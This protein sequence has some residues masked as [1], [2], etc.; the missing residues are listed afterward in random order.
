MD[1]LVSFDMNSLFTKVPIPE[2]LE[3]IQRR[4]K[5]DTTLDERTLMS[6]GTVCHLVNLYMTSTYFEFEGLLF[7]QIEGAPMD[8]PLSPVI[9]DIYYMEFF[10][11][12]AIQEAELEP[13][14]WL[15]YIDNTFVV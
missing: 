7:E 10:E 11:D 12:M 2:A 4:L 13:S 15:R 14:I 5:D 9:A 3:V 8:S 1:V 6:P